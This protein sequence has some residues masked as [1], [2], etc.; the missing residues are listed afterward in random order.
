MNNLINKLLKGIFIKVGIFVVLILVINSNIKS[1]TSPELKTSV[2]KLGH[3]WLG[4]SANGYRSSF[5]YL[6][7]YFPND[8]DIMA[9]RGQY[10][11]GYTGAGIII[12]AL[13]WFNPIA[14]SV[15]PVAQYSYTTSEFPEWNIGKVTVP[16]TN[17]LRYG[18]P[19]QV[20]NFNQ[21]GL[22]NFATVNPSY[23]EFQNH[24]FDEICEVTDSTI[25]GVNISRK[26]LA[27]SQNYNDD[28][29]INDLTFTNA[30]GVTLDS[31]YINVSES[32][33]N[34]EYSN[35][36]NPA[37]GTADD[38]SLNAN[39]WQHYYGGRPGD[40]LRVFYEYSADNP[41]KAGDNMG[42]PATTQKGR[43]LDPNMTYFA[44]L[45]ASKE[46]Y[47][48]EAQDIDDPLQPKVTYQG[49][50]TAFP[51]N[52]EN[53]IYSSSKFYVIRGG[54]SDGSPMQNAYPE[55]HHEEN[56]DEF[57]SADNTTIPAARPQNEAYRYVSF[58][59]YNIIP[60][61]KIHIV[62][63]SG[64]T[65][66]GFQKGQEIG[67]KWINGTLQDPTNMPD[68]NTGWLP[69]NFQFPAD[70]TEMDKRKDRWVSMGIDSVMLSAY[71]AKWNYD[72]NYNIPQ[73]PPPPAT[74]TVTGY[75][76]G[77]QVEWTDPEA[78]NMSNFAGYRIMSRISNADTIFYKSVYNSDAN[79]K[80]A[81]HSTKL[82]DVLFG[83]QYYFYVQSKA[84]IGE[85]DPTADPTTR[86]KIMYSS[87]VLYPDINYVQPPHFPQEDLSKIRIVPNPYNIRDP[88]LITY[89]FTDQRN[90][91]FYNLPPFCTITIYT[92]NGDLVQ[93]IQ[94]NN[95][96]GTGSEPW[97]MLTS[98]QQVI[99][100]GL[101]IAV[102]KKPDGELSYQKFVVVR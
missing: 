55:T 96:L 100:S 98:S 8:Y 6:S 71:R 47:A 3:I 42:E 51:S 12:T 78:E 69:S 54:F 14:D 40:S 13:H 81:Q 73:A 89:G 27:W 92:E 4:V 84:K 7:G 93:T 88:L 72:H 94:H 87:R 67:K 75:G 15:Q 52:A 101:Y 58:G 97:D 37:P 60:G 21:I 66:I 30:S 83:A 24:T 82:T 70:A 22:D 16:I 102:F 45:H 32:K 41:Q 38:F 49:A 33:D 23:S 48:D 86:G 91:T 1:Q 85:N 53:D 99:N 18:F 56:A 19:Q 74:V 62:Y 64:Y 43:L 90:I 20:V 50:P 95:P 44:I 29:I 28:Y 25:F 34:L 10:A 2:M 76:D 61:Q 77:V 80:A 9:N 17:Y 65:G 31:V 11:E 39:N 59:P 5:E 63:A 79:D 36:S 35:G 57:G 46:P 68:A 26:L